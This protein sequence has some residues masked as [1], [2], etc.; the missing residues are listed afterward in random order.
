MLTINEYEGDLQKYK[1]KYEYQKSLTDR[2]D[3]IEKLP[4]NQSLLNEIV[5]WKVNRFVELNDD[6]FEEI[7]QKRLNKT[8]KASLQ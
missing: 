1:D 2:L 7:G 4:F 6:I 3:N 5:L 8:K